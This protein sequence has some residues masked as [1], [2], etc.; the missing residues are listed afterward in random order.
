M[1]VQFKFTPTAND[2]DRAAVIRALQGAGFDSRPLFA[3]ATRAALAA[4][5]TLPDATSA[6]VDAVRGV[7]AEFEAAIEFVEV[8][9][10]RRMRR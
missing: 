2:N 1:S 4:I 10:D 6:H 9:P 5:Y 3:H 8:A 7:L